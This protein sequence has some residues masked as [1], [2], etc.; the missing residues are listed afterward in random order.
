MKK[1]GKNVSVCLSLHFTCYLVLCNRKKL[2]YYLTM[3][4][5]R[6]RKSTVET[7]TVTKRKPLKEVTAKKS[8]A[9]NEKNKAAPAK[10]GRP[11]K[12]SVAARKSTPKKPAAKKPTS[13]KSTA[14]S[15]TKHP[16]KASTAAKEITRSQAKELDE[17]DIF[18][19]SDVSDDE[20]SSD[21]SSQYDENAANPSQI[22]ET[23]ERFPRQKSLSRP[24][25]DSNAAPNSQSK[26]TQTLYSKLF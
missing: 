3:P 15:A 2:I 26:T 4:R 5:G 8:S 9:D 11:S 23:I 18:D 7:T 20:S 6:P 25:A 13:K 16:R 21:D 10:R 14:S 19:E 17:M 22:Y 12:A 1:C 24:V